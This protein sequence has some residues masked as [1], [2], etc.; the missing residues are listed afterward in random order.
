MIRSEAADYSLLP[1]ERSFRDLIPAFV[2]PY[3]AYVFLGSLLSSFLGEDLAQ[4]VRFAVVA[5][6]LFRFRKSY[7][8]GPRL[9]PAQIGIAVLG[10]VV[11]TA[12]WTALLRGGLALPFWQEQLVKG[13]AHEFSLLYFVMR[14]L[15]SVLLVPVLE[16]VFVRAYA[17]E[18]ALPPGPGQQGEGLLD[19]KPRALPLPPITLRT[20]A[21]A[22]LVFALGHNPP[23]WIPAI[24]YFLLTT[25]LYAWTRSF[26]VCVAVHGLTNLAIAVGVWLRPDLRFL[27]F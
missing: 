5:G 14:T 8:F 1:R 19:R 4:V 3:V 23:A 13:N 17:Q 12:A 18:A 22:G 26:R 25:A 21:V 6:L 24:A 7:R 20:I 15:S 27:W 2:V 16:E 9:T 10:A 11:A